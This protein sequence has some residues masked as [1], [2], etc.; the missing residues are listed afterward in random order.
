MECFGVG[1]DGLEKIFLNKDFVF[2]LSVEDKD[3]DEMKK[4]VFFFDVY[5]GLEFFKDKKRKSDSLKEK[6]FFIKRRWSLKVGDLDSVK[7]FII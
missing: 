6:S 7:N 1:G 5:I 3:V 2:I 4:M